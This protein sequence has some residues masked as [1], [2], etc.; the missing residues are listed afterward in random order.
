MIWGTAGTVGSVKGQPPTEIL[1]IGY[2]DGSGWDYRKE[3]SIFT[4]L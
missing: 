2:K 1:I 4:Y 3:K